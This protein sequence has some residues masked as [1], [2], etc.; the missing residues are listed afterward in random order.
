[1]Y[2][3]TFK[4]TFGCRKLRSRSAK[5]AQLELDWSM[6]GLWCICLLGQRELQADGS[7]PAS[8]SAAA[9]IKALQQT[10]REYRVRP[11]C[12]EETLWSKLRLALLDKYERDGSKTSRDYPRKKKRENIQPPKIDRATKRQ[13]KLAQQVKVKKQEFRLSA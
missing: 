10:V 2:F 7:D 1:L 8:L 11:E 6:L 9:A 5:N 12:R 4:Q 3:R 13:I